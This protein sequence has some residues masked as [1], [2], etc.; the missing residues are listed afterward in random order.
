MSGLHV[1]F[2]LGFDSQIMGHLDYGHGKWCSSI[3]CNEGKRS[4]EL[5]TA[6]HR[7]LVVRGVHHHVRMPRANS[8][9]GPRSWSAE[10]IYA[11]ATASILGSSPLAYAA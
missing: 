11:N 3:V 1:L 2:P 9:P 7:V 4:S 8:R 10:N 5:V 6:Q